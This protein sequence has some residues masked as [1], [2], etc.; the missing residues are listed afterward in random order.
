[1][2]GYNS[3]D[4]GFVPTGLQTH[5]DHGVHPDMH[6]FHELIREQAALSKEH[7]YTLHKQWF[8]PRGMFAMVGD[9]IEQLGRQAPVLDKLGEAQPPHRLL[10]V[11]QAVAFALAQ[12]NRRGAV[13]NPFMG[14]RREALC[15]VVFDESGRYTLVERYAAYE[16]IRQ[17]DAN[18]FI[19]LIATTR[20]VVE[21]RIVFRGLLEHYDRL[22]PIE[23]SIYPDGYRAA[24][25][26]HLDREE[27][28][29]GPLTLD[30]D[31]MTL[32]EKMS[33]VE[34]LE[35]VQCVPTPAT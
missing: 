30:D 13:V 2:T 31:V 7:L 3:G 27:Q 19:K 32:L 29:Y 8:G 18:L 16:A 11:E 24:Q 35:R 1:M 15:C 5:V 28:L 22:L 10:E 34:L 21:R 20:G 26:D 33:P 17:S 4:Q 14:R 12:S 6:R 23:K 25:Q 9:E